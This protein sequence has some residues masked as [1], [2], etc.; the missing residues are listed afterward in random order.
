MRHLFQR[1]G[2]GVSIVGGPRDGVVMQLLLSI[3][4]LR[5]SDKNVG[6]Y[7]FLKKILAQVTLEHILLLCMFFLN[8]NYTEI[9]F[10]FYMRDALF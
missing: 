3:F 4:L 8:K 2:S 7:I 5:S 9:L 6:V 10:S 1:S